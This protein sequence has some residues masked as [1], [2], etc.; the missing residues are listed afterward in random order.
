[1]AS[2][3]RGVDRARVVDHAQ[4]LPDRAEVPLFVEWRGYASMWRQ[5]VEWAAAV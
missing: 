5:T 3:G 4:H 1:M 2:K